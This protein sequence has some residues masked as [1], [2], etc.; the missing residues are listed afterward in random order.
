[1]SETSA[2]TEQLWY[3]R[4]VLCIAVRLTFVPTTIGPWDQLWQPKLVRRID[5]GG[6]NVSARTDLCSQ[7]WMKLVPQDKVWLPKSANTFWPLKSV[8]RTSFGH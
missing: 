6:Q 4:S 8:R 1:M 3:L 7:N 2:Q 5:F